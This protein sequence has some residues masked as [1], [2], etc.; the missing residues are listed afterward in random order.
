MVVNSPMLAIIQGVFGGNGTCWSCIFNSIG[1]NGSNYLIL[2]AIITLVTA[3]SA[4]LTTQTSL[5]TSGVNV[6]TGS[7]FNAVHVLTVVAI[8]LFMVFAA[9]PN[10]AVMFCGVNVCPPGLPQSSLVLMLNMIFGFMI[11]MSVYGI[12]KGE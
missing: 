10:F 8:A 3:V 11:V 9:V 7:A 1:A 5:G 12:F 4:A 6:S 2:A